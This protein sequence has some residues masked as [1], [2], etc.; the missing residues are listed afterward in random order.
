MVA[1]IFMKCLMVS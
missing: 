1:R